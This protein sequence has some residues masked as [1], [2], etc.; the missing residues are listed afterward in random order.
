M[1]SREAPYREALARYGM[2]KANLL[3]LPTAEKEFWD[4]VLHIAASDYHHPA[5]ELLPAARMLIRV[6]LP[7]A[8]RSVRK[9]ALTDALGGADPRLRQTALHGLRGEALDEEL[10][11]IVGEIALHDREVSVELEAV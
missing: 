5:T 3:S 8:D 7:P 11:E 6:E 10:L 1:K 9:Q 2:G 4:E